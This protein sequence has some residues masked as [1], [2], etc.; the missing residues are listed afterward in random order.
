MSFDAMLANAGGAW[1]SMFGETVTFYP[2]NGG[3]AR[4]ITAVVD[5]F[6]PERV[7]A[8]RVY[9]PRLELSVRNDATYGIAATESY[10]GGEISV[11]VRRG[12]TAERIVIGRPN[13]SHQDAGMLYIELR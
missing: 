6:P 12:G 8:G 9:R 11:A 13:P 3:T 7:D 2:P 4:T 5:R 1:T 10:I